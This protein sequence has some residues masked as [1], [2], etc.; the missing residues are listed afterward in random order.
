M[1]GLP[2]PLPNDGAHPCVWPPPSDE[3]QE[4]T[5]WSGFPW[6]GDRCSSSSAH[7]NETC[8]SEEL[9]SPSPAVPG[10]PEP[11]VGLQDGS[12]QWNWA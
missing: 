12:L 11:P 8:P 1:I 4:A 7:K 9:W 6:T 3:L 10:E 5:Q 2:L